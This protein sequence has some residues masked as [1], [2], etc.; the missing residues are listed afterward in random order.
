MADLCVAEDVELRL[1]RA[2][3]DVETVRIGVLIKDASAKIRNYTKQT[4]TE[5]TTTDNLRV[6]NGCCRLAQRPITSIV[7]VANINGAAPVFYQWNGDDLLYVGNNALD[8]F[9]WEPWRN[10]VAA[11]K[12][13]YTHGWSTVPDDIV[14]VGCSIVMRALGRT[15]TDAG[16]TSESIAG[17]SYSIGAIGAA[18][19]LGLLDAEK[20][21]LDSYR[22]VGGT[23]NTGAAWVT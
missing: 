3:T 15:P 9:G 12:V 5:A 14:G 7:T 21:I 22:R 16:M 23:V 4:I 10:G 8:S 18:G 6:R 17:Y 13:T 19:A 1:G 11:L 2:L 20:E